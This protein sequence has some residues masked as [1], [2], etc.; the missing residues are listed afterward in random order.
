[1]NIILNSNKAIVLGHRG[2]RNSYPENTRA[3]FD[4]CL[5]ANI[6]G[7]ELDVH[8][9]KDNELVIIHDFYTKRVSGVNLEVEASTLAELKTLDVGSH[10]DK[11]FSDQR[12]MTLDELFD[13][14]QNRF[15][16]DIELKSIKSHHNK[17]LCKKVLESIEKHN[18]TDHVIISSFNPFCLKT[19]R[20]LSHNTLP[21]GD[22]FSDYDEVPKFL[23]KGFGRHISGSNFLKPHL[24]QVNPSLITHLS[25]KYPIITW[26]VNEPKHIP[27]LLNLGVKAI[28]S[29]TPIL[30]QKAVDTYYTSH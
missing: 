24:S 2:Y 7:I 1:M 14:Y 12:I 8:I 13:T 20:K 15:L 21:I 4:A 28:I 18:L 22:I 16:Y 17:T 26:T 27:Q 3:S 9:T 23:R 11:K 19:F 25:K 29:D 6:K 10:L 30:I 5:Q